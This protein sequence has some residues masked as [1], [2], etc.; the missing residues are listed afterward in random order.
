MCLTV[1]ILF[2]I[3]LFQ[4]TPLA[5]DIPEYPS[6]VSLGDLDVKKKLQLDGIPKAEKN[7]YE[8]TF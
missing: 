8:K 1:Q 7:V 6:D 5:L 3:T 4:L 2:S